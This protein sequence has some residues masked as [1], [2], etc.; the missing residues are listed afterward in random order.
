MASS[1]VARK[2]QADIAQIPTTQLPQSK[3]AEGTT[4]VDM[5]VITEIA[6]SK[7]AARRLIDQGAVRINDEKMTDT[8]YTLSEANFPEGAMTLRSGKKKV[9]R[10]VLEGA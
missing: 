9:H 7:S 3:L 1:D 8:G 2:V 6:Q 5:M 4:L 10:V